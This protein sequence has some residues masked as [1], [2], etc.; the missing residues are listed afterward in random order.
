MEDSGSEVTDGIDESRFGAVR[1]SLTLPQTSK[2]VK[3]VL[4]RVS[5]KY[6]FKLRMDLVGDLGLDHSG[7]LFQ[8]SLYD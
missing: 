6:W 4:W 5:R 1:S 2:G 8:S 3:W 7:C